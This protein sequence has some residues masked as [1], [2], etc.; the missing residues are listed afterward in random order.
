MPLGTPARRMPIPEEVS[1]FLADLLGAAVAAEKVSKSEPLRDP[2]ECVTA[3]YVEDDGRLGGACVADLPF[4]ATAGAALAMMP[5]AVVDDALKAGELIESLRENFFE[6]VNILTAL[7]AGPSVPHL[8]LDRLEDGIPDEV[9]EMFAEAPGK[10][11]YNV[12]VI[13]Y[14]GGRMALMAASPASKPTKT[15]RPV[16]RPA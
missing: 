7:L 14:P 3:L 16:A 10:R 13:G 9:R 2:E 6:V 11:Q 15:V 1:D 5:K 4:A 12:S 8:R